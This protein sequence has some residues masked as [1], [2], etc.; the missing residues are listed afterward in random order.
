PFDGELGLRLLR[1]TLVS[2]AS[3]NIVAFA[4]GGVLLGLVRNGRLLP[5]DKDLDIVVPMAFFPAAL[6]ALQHLGWRPAWTAVNADN[7]RCLVQG[8]TAPG[9]GMTL[10][11]FGYAFDP[12][13]Q[14]ILGG[15]WPTGRAPEQG[16]LLQFS[17]FELALVD[18]PHGR[19][20]DLP[21]PESL[22]VELYGPDWRTPDSE[23]DTTLE[24]PALVAY[25]DYTR[26]WG[27][28]KLLEAWV[29]G[30]PARFART[31][32]VLGRL[33]P[34]DPVLALFSSRTPC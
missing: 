3:Q 7:F 28:L 1:Q 8:A 14:R 17:P 26:A 32:R 12:E 33:D 15:W 20:W 11:L 21:Q 9:P 10:D 27:R 5:H 22:L 6:N 19:H 30:R 31:L 25:N 29:Q 34:A 13:R 16:R 23:F 2:L 18:H 24:T 4:S